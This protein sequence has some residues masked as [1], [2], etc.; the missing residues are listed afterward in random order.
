MNVRHFDST[1]RDCLRKKKKKIVVCIKPTAVTSPKLPQHFTLSRFKI[2]KTL[3]VYLKPR[4]KKHLQKKSLD[5]RHKNSNRKTRKS[6][7]VEN[8]K[9][10][11]ENDLTSNQALEKV[12]LSWLS[13]N[14]PSIPSDGIAFN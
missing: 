2:L 3:A 11:F 5:T 13:S 6:F 9:T 1:P 8:F 14:Y 7:D 12:L 4:G 10:D